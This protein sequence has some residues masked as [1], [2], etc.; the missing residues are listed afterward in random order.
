VAIIVEFTDNTFDFVL[1]KELEN[2]IATN[3]IVA[4]KRSSEWVYIGKDPVRK[5]ISPERHLGRERRLCF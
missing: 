3:S 2:L 4:F 1:N 5:E